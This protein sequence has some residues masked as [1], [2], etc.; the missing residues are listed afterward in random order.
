MLKIKARDIVSDIRAR[1]S[2]F[3]LMV[4]YALS[5]DELDTVLNRLV[6]EREIRLEELLERSAFFDDPANR[7]ETRAFPRA[8]LRVPL[9][10]H[11]SNNPSNQGVITDMSLTGFRA[12]GIS[13][14]IGD[15]KDLVID[16]SGI[17]S[18]CTIELRGTCRWTN[19]KGGHKWLWESGYNITTVTREALSTIQK[20]IA[21]LNMGDRNLMRAKT[22]RS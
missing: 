11:E 15:A 3:E 22:K 2:D 21:L 10:V 17:E 14:E 16:A 20:V 7:C 6:D 5:P 8:Y 1:V 12:R 19:K 9:P 18:A 4:K 13:A